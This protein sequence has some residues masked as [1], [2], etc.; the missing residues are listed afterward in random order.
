MRAR[1]KMSV[2]ARIVMMNIFSSFPE[3]C[4]PCRAGGGERR[5]GCL[6]GWPGRRPCA[7][8]WDRSVS[9][10]ES[11]TSDDTVPQHPA[12]RIAI[13]SRRS[14]FISLLYHPP[15]EGAKAI[16][17]GSGQAAVSYGVI[18]HSNPLTGLRPG[19]TAAS[20]AQHHPVRWKAQRPSLFQ[21]VFP[22]LLHSPRFPPRVRRGRPLRGR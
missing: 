14:F 16:R 3:A 13:N 20:E 12:T 18:C 5:R 4:K 1:T 17:R 9:G 10:V 6:Q 19:A 22:V 2:I 21:V 15:L 8:S 11:E 7:L